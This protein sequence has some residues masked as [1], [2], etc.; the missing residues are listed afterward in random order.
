MQGEKARRKAYEVEIEKARERII[1][2]HK[3]CKGTGFLKKVSKNKN[4][5]A[6]T[7][8]TECKCRR[9]FSLV[10]RF[11]LSN[12]P[13]RIVANQQIYP[14]LVIDSITE[15][16]LELRNTIVDPIIKN[17]N[18]FA[19]HPYG[20]LLLGKNGT[21]KTFVG[22]KIIYYSIA[23]KL[24]AHYIE[25]QDLLK[26]IRRGFSNDFDSDRLLEEIISVDVLLIDEVGSESKRS[27][28]AISELKSVYKKRVNSF[29]PTILISNYSY[30][31]FQKVYGKSIDNLL[32]SYSRILDFSQATDVRRGK[33]SS[34][35]D[36]FFRKIKSK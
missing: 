12:L 27:E 29:K 30:K 36:A 33:C 15:D 26:L 5:F 24:T 35:M 9:K 22:L 13:S 2:K 1:H 18:Q 21:G 25:F 34:E 17:L 10:S 28:H 31:N 20:L 23:E 19:H 14:K 3:K 6:N 7:A 11:I 32:V 4:G 8:V 16:A